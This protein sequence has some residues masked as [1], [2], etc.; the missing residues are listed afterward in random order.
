MSRN[1]YVKDYRLAHYVDEHG[2]IRTETYYVG[3]NYN[4]TVPDAQV[5]SSAIRLA[6]ICAVCWLSWIAVLVPQTAVVMHRYYFS[7][8]FVACAV[9]LW[10]MSEVA[11]IALRSK[12][13]VR[14]READKLSKGMFLRALFAVIFSS[15]SVVGL[16]VA[17]ALNASEFNPAD[18]FAAG[19]TVLLCAASVYA[20]TLRKAFPTE[21][22]KKEPEPEPE[23]DPDPQEE[24]PAE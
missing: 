3:G 6:V 24:T 9:P 19:F 7:V 1:K 16:I 13:P 20:F 8:Q 4:F 23:E 10:L 15:A 5:R 14:H 21:Q 11:F 2:K 18:Y 12:S 22:E 17:L